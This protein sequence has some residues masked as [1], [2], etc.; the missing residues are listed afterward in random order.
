M[1]AIARNIYLKKLQSGKRVRH[2]A[3]SRELRPCDGRCERWCDTRFNRNIQNIS[4]K[5]Q[6]GLDAGFKPVI[7]GAAMRPV[8]G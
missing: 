2:D 1:R 6:G 8:M 7:R 3:A 5:N 4:R